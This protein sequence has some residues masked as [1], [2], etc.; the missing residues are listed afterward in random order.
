MLNNDPGYHTRLEKTAHEVVV[1]C[2]NDICSSVPYILG[3]DPDHQ[4]PPKVPRAFNGNLLLWPLYNAG[5]T[6][7][8]PGYQRRWVIERLRFIADVMGVR[9]ASP[10]V[11]SLS[12]KVDLGPWHGS[13]NVTN[14]EHESCLLAMDND[15]EI[16]QTASQQLLM[17]QV[18]GHPMERG[19]TL[20]H[21]MSVMP[22]QQIQAISFPNSAPL[23]MTSITSQSMFDETNDELSLTGNYDDEW[24]IKPWLDPLYRLLT[25]L[26]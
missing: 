26:I 19:R 23:N 25:C 24:Y 8:I 21:M 2:S 14:A 11:Q 16:T 12:A 9:Q 6:E 4:G 7:R 3:Y 18:I 17:E 1:Q 22:A 5:L 20:P 15:L 13:S 10:L